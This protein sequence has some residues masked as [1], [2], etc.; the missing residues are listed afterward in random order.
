MISSTHS[1]APLITDEENKHYTAVKS[2]SRL[3]RSRNSKHKCKQHF[4]LNCLQGFTLEESRD[5]HLEY[6]FDNEA[7]KV[8]MP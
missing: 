6:C 7:V 3:F 5:K 1:G 2:L 4:C 8:E